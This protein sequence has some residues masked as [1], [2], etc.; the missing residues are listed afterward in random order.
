MVNEDRLFRTGTAEAKVG[1]HGTSAPTDTAIDL[2]PRAPM[3][4]GREHLRVVPAIYTTP[5]P[6]IAQDIA[7]DKWRR[8]RD[9][10]KGEGQRPQMYEV[11]VAPSETVELGDCKDASAVKGAIELGADVLECPDWVTKGGKEVPEMVILNDDV[12]YTVRALQI[13]EMPDRD[14]SKAVVKA[15]QTLRAD[16]T[17]GPSIKRPRGMPRYTRYKNLPVKLQ[18]RKASKPKQHPY[19]GKGR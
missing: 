2:E 6:L 14:V 4:D 7:F 16:S 13:N 8:A 5:K 17:L 19:L 1:W 10:G 12:H 3:V 11:V 18:K 9:K 15:E